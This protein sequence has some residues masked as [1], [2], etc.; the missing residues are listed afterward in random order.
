MG[1]LY[2]AVHCART[3][4]VFY[5]K[6]LLLISIAEPILVYVQCAVCSVQCK[7]LLSFLSLQIR[8]SFILSYIVLISILAVHVIMYNTKGRHKGGAG[9]PSHPT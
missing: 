9:V 8:Y 6:K 2:I 3:V 1:T 7:R 5:L 4:H